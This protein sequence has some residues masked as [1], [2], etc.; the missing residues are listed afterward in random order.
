METSSKRA[1]AVASSEKPFCSEEVA[2]AGDGE[3]MVVVRSKL[4]RERHLYLRGT[5]R[6]VR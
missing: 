5:N 3:D 2:S 4:E 1:R 6:G